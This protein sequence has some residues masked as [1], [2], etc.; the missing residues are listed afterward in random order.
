MI[1]Y[2]PQPYDDELWYSVCSRFSEQMRF[3]TETGVMLALY[4][5]RHAIAT[6]D[7]PH[8]LQSVSSQL[9]PGHPCTVGNIIDHHTFLPYYGPFLTNTSY[10]TVRRLMEDGTKPSVRVRCGA[11]TNRVRPPKYF[12]S[13]PG[14]DRENRRID[15]ETYWRRLFQLPGVEVCTI[16]NVFLEPSDI[17]LD[18]LPNR[19]KYF[20]ANSARLVSVAHPVD[21][22]D[23][24]QI[25]LMKLAGDIEWLLRQ[26][27][28][29]PGLEVLHARYGQVLTERG[30]ATKAGSL[31]MAEIRRK[32]LLR[33]GHTLL[34]LLQSDL[35]DDKGDGWLGH[36][37]RKPSTAV[38]PL[39]HLLLLRAL[40]LSLERFFIPEASANRIG[41][42]HPGIDP[43]SCLSPICDRRGERL[44]NDVQL[45][46]PDQNGNRHV[47]VTCQQCGFSYQGRDT[48]ER[49]IKASRVVDYGPKWINL[50]KQQ[51]A[52]TNVT[53]R[54]MAKALGVDPKTVKQRAAEFGLKFPR[55]G[56]RPV[57]KR[58]LY[59][60]ANR[61]KTKSVESHRRE[62][63]ELVENNPKCG[64][65]QLRSLA[66]A[67]YARLYRS[68]RSWLVQHKPA[69]QR[70]A[71][72]RLHVDWA[73]RDEEL[74]G[75]IATIAAHIK[76]HPGRPNRVTVT[77][78]GR[79]LGK[80][81]LFEAALAKLPLTRSVIKSV[82]E[83]DEDFAVRRVHSAARK[84]RMTEG[85]F[86]RWKLVRAAG[87]HYRLERQEKVK[88]ALDYEIRPTVKVTM[89]RDGDSLPREFRRRSKRIPRQMRPPAVVKAAA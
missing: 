70:P 81:S 8:R 17:R 79:A 24:A 35:P 31:R 13:C 64:T 85:T 37:L 48:S 80:Q 86:A 87:L 89:L 36:L 42:I 51:W 66:P 30:F 39:R 65:K 82:L 12:R 22:K 53:L 49:P 29:N 58:G 59:V 32:I 41:A 83:S 62:W 55:K 15:G 34:Q 4:G 18:P 84:L 61:D 26:D 56:K 1:G 27:R 28:L 46:P 14:C 69:R 74:V 77:A 38:A 6:V 10:R 20:S 43:W 2:F 5:R 52:D 33:Y 40:E 21:R 72:A 75:Q 47:I 57:T 88:A 67:L 9:P 76:N 3:G 7:L 68:D 23:P 44:I 63:N 60:A 16:H 11:C 19:H 78:I 54:Q 50:L 25:V 73:K 71:I 45:R